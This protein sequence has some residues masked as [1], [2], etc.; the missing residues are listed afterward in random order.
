MLTFDIEA[1][2]PNIQVWPGVDDLCLFDIVERAIQDITSLQPGLVEFLV[3]L[4]HLVLSTQL[5]QCGDSFF[6]IH[7]GFFHWSSVRKR[8]GQS[9]PG[10]AG[11]TCVAQF[12]QR[13]QVSLP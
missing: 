9:S 2:N 3:R 7:V 4:L 11:L 1:L 10:C 8:V 5:T 13:S 12:R 6:E